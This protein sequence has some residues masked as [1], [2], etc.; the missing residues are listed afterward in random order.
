[1]G[2]GDEMTEIFRRQVGQEVTYLAPARKLKATWS[3]EAQQDLRSQYNLDTDA[4]EELTA[5][6]VQEISLNIDRDILTDLRSHIESVSKYLMN[7]HSQK[8][9]WKKEGF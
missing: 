9:D 4:E 1:M 2:T 7:E 5:I 8:I 6:L 3:Y